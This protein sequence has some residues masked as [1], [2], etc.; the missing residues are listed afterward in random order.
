MRDSY[1]VVLTF[2]SHFGEVSGECGV[3]LTN[4]P[5]GIEN[6]VTQISRTALL[7]VGVAV[8]KLAGLVGGG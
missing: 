7:H 3:P 5:R 2:S 4:E 6:G 8:G 1:I